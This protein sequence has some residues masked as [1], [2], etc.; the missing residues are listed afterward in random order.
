MSDTSQGEGW[1]QASDGKWY[2]PDLTKLP[3]PPLAEGEW[4]VKPGPSGK[5]MLQAGISIL[6][7]GAVMA[8]LFWDN[9]LR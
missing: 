3:A 8:L 6:V 4:R 9:F 7:V 5:Q 2:P 1:W